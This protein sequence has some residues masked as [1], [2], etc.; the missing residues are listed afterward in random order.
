KGPGDTVFLLVSYTFCW[1]SSRRDTLKPTFTVAS[2][3]GTTSSSQ[4]TVPT[5]STTMQVSTGASFPI[6]NYL[7]PVST[8]SNISANGTVLKTAGGSTGVMQLPGGFTFMPG[9]FEAS[10]PQ[11]H[12]KTLSF[13]LILSLHVLLMPSCIGAY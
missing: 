5:T 2:L 3:P 7:A 12:V 4:S 1:R 13:F 9:M 8:S 6:T 11:C 10:C